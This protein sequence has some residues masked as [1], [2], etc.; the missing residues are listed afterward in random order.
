MTA[1]DAPGRVGATKD[2]RDIRTGPRLW[3]GGLGRL[4]NPCEGIPGK[5]DPC[6]QA[7]VR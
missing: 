2:V 4:A 7:A 1:P 5:R 3:A 6:G